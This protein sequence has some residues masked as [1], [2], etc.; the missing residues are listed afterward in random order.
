[1]LLIGNL[2]AFVERKGTLIPL[3]LTPLPLMHRMCRK[4]SRGVVCYT[5]GSRHL[6]SIYANAVLDRTASVAREGTEDGQPAVA[7]APQSQEKALRKQRRAGFLCPQLRADHYTGSVILQRNI[8]NAF[9]LLR[10]FSS[11]V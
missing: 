9:T 11:S 10:Y 2:A 5:A 4:P 3:R 8:A 1:L 6:G 7:K